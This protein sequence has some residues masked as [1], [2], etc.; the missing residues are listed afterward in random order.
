MVISEI[1]HKFWKSSKGTEL[2]TVAWQRNYC[3]PG[4]WVEAR[5]EGKMIPI[6][7][8]KKDLLT[9]RP[10]LAESKTILLKALRM[11]KKNPDHFH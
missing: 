4:W 6:A 2:G 9:S 3:F 1:K 7:G 8:T 11:V 5:I 10:S